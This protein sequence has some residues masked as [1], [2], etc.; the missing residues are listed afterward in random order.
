M[1]SPLAGLSA[2]GALRVGCQGGQG[3]LRPRSETQVMLPALP[4]SG[5]IRISYS[6]LKL[7]LDRENP[8]GRSMGVGRRGSLSSTRRSLAGDWIPI[9]RKLLSMPPF[10]VA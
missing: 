3:A 8:W 9:F 6:C 5:E 10:S 1:Q 4:G 2:Q 7:F